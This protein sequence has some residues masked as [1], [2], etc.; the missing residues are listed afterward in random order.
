MI[1]GGLPSKRFNFGEFELGGLHEKLAVA[2]WSLGTI[3]A[4]LES[5]G[6]PRKPVSRWP[7]AGPSGYVLTSNCSLAN[8]RIDKSPKV[9]LTYKLLY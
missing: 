1:F 2:A 8:K 6:K 3:S 7:V 4:L 5:R 9:S